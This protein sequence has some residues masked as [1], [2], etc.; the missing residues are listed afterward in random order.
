MQLPRFG[1]FLLLLALTAPLLSPRAATAEEIAR[2]RKIIPFD[3]DWLFLKADAPGAEKP[4][5]DDSQW[6]KLDVPHDWSI[7]GPFD[8]NNPAGGAGAFLPAGVGWY[9]KH[10]RL[11]DYRT[12]A[13]VF[14][15]FDGVMANGDVWINGY[16]LGKR[17]YG[18]VSFQ[19][20]LTGH[21]NDAGNILAVRAD[22]SGQPASRWY[23]GAGIYRH[24][25][26]LVM[27][28]V[29]LD[30]WGV[31]VRTPSITSN[32]AT[33]TVQSTL[34]DQA[35]VAATVTVQTTIFDPNGQ[36]VQKT[37]TTQKV[38]PDAP[39]T[40]V[41]QVTVPH[42]QV[43]DLD[44]PNL[45]HAWVQVCAGNAKRPIDDDL[46]TFG[47]REFHFDAATG[48]WLNGRNFKI[49]GVCLHVDGGA[50][51]AAI[52]LGTWE[53]YLTGLKAAGANAIRTAHNPPA[54]EF[55]DL[56]D[57]MGFLVMDEM[58]D[59]WTVGKNDYDYHLYFNQWS[60]T[61]T[62]D[63]VR[64]DRNHP[65]IILY[66][67]GNE[68]HDTPDAKLAKGI[69][70]GLID[71]FHQNDPTRPVTQ[72]LFRP[73]RSGD[74]TDGLADML[75]VVGQNYREHEILAAH[76][77]NP[78]RKI[79]GTE[80]GHDRL[81]WLELRDNPPYAGQFLWTGVDY[82]GEARQWPGISRATGLLDRT[83]MPYPRAFQ[84]ASWWSDKPLVSIVRRTAPDAPTVID[85][86]YNLPAPN[87]PNK[88]RRNTFADWSPATPNKAGEQ[89]EVY[90]NCEQVELFLN[91][92]S[93]GAQPLPWTVPFEPGS[94]KAIGRNGGAIAASDELKTA[95]APAKI[96]LSADRQTLA[97][98]W[99]NVS[100]VKASITDA[101][102]IEVPNADDLVTFT[103]AGPGEIAAVD[104]SDNSSQESF[105]AKQRHA[106]Q[107]RCF[108]IVRATGAGGT[109][110]LT[111]SA[112]GRAPASITIPTQAPQAVAL[113]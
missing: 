74:Y 95:G 7:E 73:N 48:F 76:A 101:N 49:K 67:A 51:G 56:C 47:I 77:Q 14:I 13:R 25:R 100:Y 93:L 80:N 61:D 43:W 17:P 110:T 2:A 46:V 5:F 19:Y 45:Y 16:H 26:L 15:E 28:P 91:G 96:A 32:A 79:I 4:D 10:F 1:T 98:G 105:Q 31:A 27:A 23:S 40:L 69:L 20:E 18:Y 84:R 71:V 86:G 55:L 111:A 66:S 103:I 58:F 54:P 65:S 12:K 75:D 99:D 90:S 29:H 38:S 102:G 34:V 82:L 107:G 8:P 92:K 41:Q 81:I 83:G 3:T 6:R 97:P 37:E 64:R 63:S 39:A 57:R 104:N 89:V 30:E 85:P 78:A 52:P 113:K 112:P 70:G 35:P 88:Y 50:F 22:N 109:I 21:L 33:V 42:P 87:S 72:A 59:C 44:T 68:I 24:V 94:L 11:P 60:K 53:R 36:V 62:A 108:A 9:R 106:Y